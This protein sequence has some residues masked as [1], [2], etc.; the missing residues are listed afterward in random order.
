[1]HEGGEG[2]NSK[3]KDS[4][5]LNTGSLYKR[6][7]YIA[8]LTKYISESRSCIHKECACV[9]QMTHSTVCC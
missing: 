5:E 4:S 2:A 1:M 9:K 7:L 3:S 6:G 8:G